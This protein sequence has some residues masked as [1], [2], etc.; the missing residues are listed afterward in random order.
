MPVSRPLIINIAVG[1]LLS[2]LFGALLVYFIM[3]GGVGSEISFSE[4]LSS[5]QNTIFT[6]LMCSFVFASWVMRGSNN[7]AVLF[8]WAVVISVYQTIYWAT[9]HYFYYQHINIYV[10][11]F[12]GVAASIPAILFLR[13]RVTYSCWMLGK[14]RPLRL[15]RAEIDHYL[16]HAKVTDFEFYMR[17]VMYAAF[18]IEY[19]YAAYLTA[20]ALFF[21]IPSDGSIYEHMLQN[22]FWD[23]YETY[24]FAKN[25]STSSY[26]LVI[27]F[28]LYRDNQ[29]PDAFNYGVSEEQKRAVTQL[30][31]EKRRS[32]ARRKQK[33]KGD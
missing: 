18:F 15:F 19:A 1:T 13:L 7:R 25:L 8:F 11:N 14:V 27:G 22:N 29:V 3:A 31:L 30:M 6:L 21:Q 12:V 26:I 4:F 16:K 23:P 2:G 17:K 24:V 33:K 32:E 9:Y 28:Y 10:L 5:P 20:Y